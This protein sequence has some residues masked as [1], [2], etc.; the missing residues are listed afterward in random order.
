MQHGVIKRNFLTLLVA[1]N[2]IERGLPIG[3]IDSCQVG[4]VVNVDAMGSG[5]LDQFFGIKRHAENRRRLGDKFYI[6]EMPDPAFFQ[7]IRREVGD[8]LRSAGAFD[9]HRRLG[10]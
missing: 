7:K 10:K 4:I 5:D 6:D 8:L 1:R 3:R 2:N 9:R